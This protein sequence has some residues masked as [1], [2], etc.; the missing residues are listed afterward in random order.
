MNIQMR[1]I[2]DENVDQLTSMSYSNNINKL[3]KTEEY[4]IKKVI[5]LYATEINNKINNINRFNIPN[6]NPILPTQDSPEVADQGNQYWNRGYAQ[7]QGAVYNNTYGYPDVSSDSSS[8]PFGATTYKPASPDFSPEDSSQFVQ[9]KS[10]DFSPESSPKIVQGEELPTG[11]QVLPTGEIVLPPKQSLNIPF[12]P[13]SLDNQ[14]TLVNSDMSP[15]TNEVTI[16]E[17]ESKPNILNVDE[18]KEDKPPD[19]NNESKDS[20]SSETKRIINI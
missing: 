14:N 9:P 10:P 17:P 15:E 2:T 3:L 16:M 7:Q 11:S 20:S 19:S 6:E 13:A 18:A 4:D 12:I 1:I 8:D 5:S